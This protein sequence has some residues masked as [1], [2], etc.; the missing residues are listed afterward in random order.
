MRPKN[1]AIRND[2]ND[3]LKKAYPQWLSCADIAKSLGIPSSYTYMV[4]YYVEDLFWTQVFPPTIARL[5]QYRPKKN[6][7]R[8]IP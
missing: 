2:I 7:Y 1:N 6:S 5:K 3:V 4:Y 8:A